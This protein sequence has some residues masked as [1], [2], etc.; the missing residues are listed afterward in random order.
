MHTNLILKIVTSPQANIWSFVLAS[1]CE[2]KTSLIIKAI[3]LFI[4]IFPRCYGSRTI[5]NSLEKQHLLTILVLTWPKFLDN[6]CLNDIVSIIHVSLL[7][8]PCSLAN[9][10]F[11][12]PDKSADAFLFLG[13]KD[14]SQCLNLYSLDIQS[15]CTAPLSFRPNTQAKMPKPIFL[16]FLVPQNIFVLFSYFVIKQVVFLPHHYRQLPEVS[17]QEA[18]RDSYITPSPP[19]GKRPI[20]IEGMHGGTKK[21][22]LQSVC[23][24][25]SYRKDPQI[26]WIHSQTELNKWSKNSNNL[27]DKKDMRQC[28]FGFKI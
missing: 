7:H 20:K 23:S 27:R 9:G 18:L 25:P 1:S 4:L 2:T 15:E 14:S 10:F 3:C 26:H 22:F 28:K 17:L 11:K 8:L 12:L 16:R 6:F 24:R 21:F 19:S 5:G 13:E